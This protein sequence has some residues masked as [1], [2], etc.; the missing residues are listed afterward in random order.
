[1]AAVSQPTR[2]S[3]RFPFPPAIP[4]LALLLSWGMGRL[5][6]I[7]MNWPGWLRGVGWV[8]IIAAAVLVL[9]AFRTFRRHR[10]TVNPRGQVTAMVESG[11]F[12]Y[13]RNPMYLSLLVL[14]VGGTLAFQLPWAA[15]LFIPVFLALHF[16]V[17]LPEEAYLSAALGEPYRLYRQRVRRWF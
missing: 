13:T 15:I 4:L 3:R 7:E 2:D 10:T 8:L 17:V 14:Y 6:P 5:W 16:S 11:P 9:S 1:M 12:R